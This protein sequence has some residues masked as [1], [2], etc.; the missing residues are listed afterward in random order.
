MPLRASNNPNTDLTIL[1]V[2]KAILPT[3]TQLA[4]AS[5]SGTGSE[6]IYIQSKYSMSLGMTAAIPIAVNLS[7]GHQTYQRSSQR[8]YVGILDATVS[9]YSRW[10]DQDST[11]DAIR[12]N[13]ALDL[14]R[15]KSNAET[16]DSL[17]YN[18]TN[19]AISIPTISLSPYDAEYDRTFSGLTLVYRTMTLGINI[20]P[21]DV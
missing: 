10:D 19:Y 9:Y 21:Y 11:I 16:N 1:T 17:E 2:L 3:N 20:L 13:I 5:T 18:G 15:M 7:S 12:A 14:E 4:A 6:L 8:T